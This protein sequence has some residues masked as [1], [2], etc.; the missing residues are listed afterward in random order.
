M[1]HFLV[2]YE[3]SDLPV[4]RGL[5]VFSRRITITGI[6]SGQNVLN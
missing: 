2:T 3:Q 4:G 5:N 6:H 1:C